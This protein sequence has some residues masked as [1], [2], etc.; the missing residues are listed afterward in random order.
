MLAPALVDTELDG[1]EPGRQCKAAFSYDPDAAIIQL[2]Q[3]MFG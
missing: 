2:D 1:E 3:R